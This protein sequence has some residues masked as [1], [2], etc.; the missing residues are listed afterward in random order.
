[1]V[2]THGAGELPEAGAFR[3]QAAVDTLIAKTPS[4]GGG[5]VCLLTAHSL[6]TAAVAEELWHLLAPEA[7]KREFDAVAGAPGRGIRLFR[8]ICALHDF[9]KATPMFQARFPSYTRQVLDAGLEYDAGVHERNTGYRHER[10]GAHLLREALKQAGWP[11]VHREWLWPLIAGHHG[12]IPGANGL[13]PSRL[14]HRLLGGARWQ[15]VREALLSRISAETGFSDWARRPPVQVPGRTTQ[16]ALCGLLKLAD[17]LSSGLG[18]VDDPSRVSYALSR[19]RVRK[20]CAPAVPAKGWGPALPEPDDSVLDARYGPGW[21]HEGLTRAVLGLTRAMPSGGLLVVETYGDVLDT[22]LVAA[23]IMASRRKT[24]GI[25]VGVPEWSAHHD[26]FRRVRAWLG[27]L[28][29]SYAEKAVL[30]H[31]LRALDPEWSAAKYPDSALGRYLV[32]ECPGEPGSQ[33]GAFAGEGRGT[34]LP[35]DWFHGHV[36]GLL[37][38]FVVAP[39][40]QALAAAVRTQYVMVRMA[41][42]VGKV[43]VLDIADFL[44]A[45]TRVYLLE[46]LRWLGEA[47]VPVVLLAPALSDAGRGRL[48][49]AWLGG[50]L[51]DEAYRGAVP[52]AAPA[53]PRVTAA[54]VADGLPRTTALGVD[55]GAGRP[56]RVQAVAESA[57]SL[58][59]DARARRQADGLLASR[60]AARLGPGQRA[61]IVRNSAERAQTLLPALREALR[62][63][64]TVVLLHTQLAA[65]PQAVRAREVLARLAPR[66]A[67]GGGGRY[68]VIADHLVERAFP[69]QVDLLVSDV[70]PVESLLARLGSLRADPAPAAGL[71]VTGYAAGGG[72]G[73]DGPT[74]PEESVR[75]YG[76]AGLVAATALVEEAAAT[77]RGWRL[78]DDVDALVAAAHGGTHGFAAAWRVRAAQAR[79]EGR[80]QTASAEAQAAQHALTRRG[81]HGSAHLAGLSYLSTPHQEWHLPALVRGEGCPVETLAVIRDDHG[82]TSLLGHRLAPDGSVKGI[83]DAAVEAI[84]CGA[85][86]LPPDC[87]P[88]GELLDPLPAWEASSYAGGARRLRRSRALV[89]D[90][91]LRTRLGGRRLRYD[92]EL[93]LL[94]E[95]PDE[96]FGT[97]ATGG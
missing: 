96:E 91:D 32:S 42:L 78:P 81:E 54:W 85:V 79:E 64:D 66:A 20:V 1:M 43:L 7:L 51:D 89:F 38:P 93:G 3:P 69:A 76:R 35:V 97:T 4:H 73:R 19:E 6:D 84:R 34:L 72:E 92:H 75:L 25:F 58:A 62:E 44:D 83:P 26:V 8:W 9:G 30:L 77:G 12:D 46:A 49:D 10:A 23:E 71:L 11:R 27:L 15:Q 45:R 39:A 17:W 74:F 24:A 57:A 65:G 48:L 29:A 59:G 53:H 22:G 28:D 33:D 36:R 67:T 40:Y 82:Y 94:D 2:R 95:G 5:S 90:T 21:R 13:L 68:V 86:R 18:G 31:E 70:A 14:R 55:A 47:R 87:W 88:S 61:L 16:L 63:D 37:A 50:A 80:R 60:V 56:V 52:A 41:G